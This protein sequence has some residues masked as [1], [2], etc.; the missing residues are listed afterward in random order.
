M[1][2]TLRETG[3]RGLEC[4]GEGGRGRSRGKRGGGGGGGGLRKGGRRRREEV[5]RTYVEGTVSSQVT[6]QNLRCPSSEEVASTP[7]SGERER[8][9]RG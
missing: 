7:A 1:Q 3:E 5:A 8:S 9:S 6:C 2:H 4:E